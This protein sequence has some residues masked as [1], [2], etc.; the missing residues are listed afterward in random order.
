M[1]DVT[2][3]QLVWFLLLSVLWLGYF[4]LEGFDFGVGMLIGAVA[5]TEAEKRTVFHSIGPVWDGNEVWLIVA[6]AG[7]FAAFP[8][9][10]ATLFSGFYIPLFLILVALI[11]R[12]VSFEFWG[13][14]DSPRW[15]RGWEWALAVGSFLPA[16]LWGVAWANIV[17]GVPIDAE[18]EFTGT[19]LDLLSPYA[20]LGGLL[21]L[22]LFLCHGAS[23]LTLRT[24]GVVAERAGK[25]ARGTAPVAAV[26]GLA[27]V[28]WTI[29][30]Q[31]DRGGV[32]AVSAIL[33]VLAVAALLA[34]TVLVRRN[35]AAG[36]GAGIGAIVLLFTALFVDLFPNA[37]VSSTDSANDLTLSAASSSDYTLTVMTVVAVLLVP[38]VLLYQGWT[39]WVFR[40]RIGPEDFGEV[41]TPLDLID[42]KLEERREGG[43]EGQG[44]GATPT[45]GET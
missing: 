19:L 38:F 28:A 13:K 24:K 45:Q 34:M 37:M 20:L 9:W 30:D 33:G 25:W 29:A 14:E 7:T 18:A 36:F 27:F 4:V 22:S 5:R 44:P 2:T 8:E 6:G 15:R 43:D 42:R 21:T 10:Y 16:L 31:S 41:R 17:A 40:H 35:T 26:L 12:G 11:V 1:D 3:L 39:Y 23:F 32:D